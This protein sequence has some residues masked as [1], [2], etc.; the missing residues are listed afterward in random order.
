MRS[1]KVL[2][3]GA[4][5]GCERLRLVRFSYVGFDGATHDDGELVVLDAVADHVLE[6]FVTLRRRA[7]PIAGARLM[8][9]Y[10]GDD[11]AS[12]ADNNTSAF[13]VRR[14][15]GRAAMSL[16]AYGVAIDINPIQ[17]PY[18]ERAARTI[19]V[20]PPAGTAYLG[21]QDRRPGM[22]ETVI[23]VFAHHG[24]AQWG[25]YWPRGIDYQ[26]FQIGRRLAGQLATLPYPKARAAF[27]Q[28]V[29][30]V[31]ACIQASRQKR[32]RSARSCAT[33]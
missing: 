24:F 32:P 17:N 29:E 20:S 7:F 10:R 4:P 15:I 19:E 30:R 18:V 2:N 5:I 23:D 31:R 13:N 9:R 27:E 22:A 12:I 14:V 33:I 25:G 3:A 26:H 21:R 16:H 6:I 28:H 8:N 11:D 1:T